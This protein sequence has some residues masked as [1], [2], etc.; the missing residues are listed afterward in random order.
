L[1]PVLLVRLRLVTGQVVE[2]VERAAAAIR[3]AIGALGVRVEPDPT[4]PQVVALRFVLAD[5][6]AAPFAAAAPAT[7]E[8]GRVVPAPERVWMG[9]GED[10]RPWWL[11]VGPHLLVAGATGSGKG[12]VIWSLLFALAPAIKTGTVRVH[13]IDLKGGV[14]LL[15]G[16]ALCCRVATS[17]EQAVAVLTDLVAVMRARL[18]V[19]AARGVRTHTATLA[20]PLHVVL[21]D[22]FGDL[23]AYCP[24]RTLAREAE[25]LMNLLQTQGRAPGIWVVAALQDPAKDV[26]PMRDLFPM[27]VGLRLASTSQTAMVLG[28]AAVEQGAACHRITRTTPG[29]GYVRPEDGGPPVRVRAG[30]ASDQAIRA[31]AATFAA[32]TT[33]PIPLPEPVQGEQDEPAGAGPGAGPGRMPRK[34]RAPRAPRQRSEQTSPQTGEAA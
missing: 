34:P 10:G 20:E 15:L 26:V 30:Y 22:E 32:P 28:D 33:E 12:S 7:P 17:H 9:R 21:L 1:G 18:D 5:L 24:D 6:L 27:R 13:G 3:T 14:E 11:P 4:R 2:D 16:R 25:R 8:I 23:I 19:M 29:V 31:V